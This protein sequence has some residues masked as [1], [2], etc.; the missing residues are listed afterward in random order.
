MHDP[1]TLALPEPDPDSLGHSKAVAA[2]VRERI[3][4][5]GGSI[6]F[7]E[8]MHLCLY[9]PALGY[10][11]AGATKFGQ[12][13]DFVTAPEVSAL[14]GRTLARQ[15]AGILA[16]LDSPAIL[17]IGAGS[18]KLAADILEALAAADTLPAGGYCILEVSPD[19]QQRQRNLLAERVPD[20]IDSVRW[21]N[22]MPAGF[23]GV[24][25]ANELLD[26]L[27]VERFVR[28]AGGIRQVGVASHAEA[29]RLVERDA[30]DKLVQAVEHIEATIGEPLPD[31]YASDVCLAVRPWVADLAD[32]LATGVAFLF[33]YGVGR[34]E[35]YAPDRSGG[36]LR[37][38]FR[39]HAHD[40]PLILQGIQDLT[41]WVDFTAVAESAV[42]NGLEIAG[43]TSQAQFLV[44]A[45]L[46]EAL[47]DFARMPTAAQLRLSAEIKLLTLPTEMGENFKCLGLMRG[48]FEPP[49]AFG[50][51]DRTATLG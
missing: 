19:L 51:A 16:Q 43:F 39:H 36:W 4:G 46:E 44:G 17:E 23:T 28:R 40:D 38:H 25:I 21:L 29:F 34:R 11:A 26:A 10:Y 13:G 20:L 22:A 1:R 31:G 49:A 41:S 50:R 27:P 33:D 7:A 48:A 45:G 14:F 37:C 32:S 6:S 3:A 47:A 35:Y 9:A 24:V 15:S 18:G 5:A 30:P 12:A 8:Y 42:D 2:Y